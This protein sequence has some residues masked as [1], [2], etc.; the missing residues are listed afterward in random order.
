[1]N[2]TGYLMASA[3]LDSGDWAVV[4]AG[5][6]PPLL[7]RVGMGLTG[8]VLF[9]AVVRWASS[10][11]AE[12]IIQGTVTGRDLTRLT[13]PPYIAGGALFIA[14]ATLNPI[15]QSLI[16]ASGA[17]ASLG[18][19]FGLLLIPGMVKGK[20]EHPEVMYS[21]L[22]LSKSWMVSAALVA[23]IFIGIFG[24]GIRLP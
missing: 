10:T 6:H 12:W 21:P 24:R 8:V 20:T 14:A 5:F 19:T 22:Q 4:V 1:M 18:L 17:G 9:S 3:M 2:G 15:S 13:V 23:V 7:W 11:M 16:L